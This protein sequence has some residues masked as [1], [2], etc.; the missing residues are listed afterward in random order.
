MITMNMN[1]NM[2]II[3]ATPII[4]MMNNSVVGYMVSA[5]LLQVNP[6]TEKT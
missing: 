4:T 1:T 3:M 2:T 6:D 5:V